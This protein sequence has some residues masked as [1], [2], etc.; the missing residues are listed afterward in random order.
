MCECVCVCI[1]VCMYI[2][3]KRSSTFTIAHRPMQV[4]IYTFTR[5]CTHA[6]THIRTRLVAHTHKHTHTHAR[7]NTNT[8]KI[9]K[10]SIYIFADQLYMHHKLL[11]LGDLILLSVYIIS[12]LVD[13]A[14]FVLIIND[15]KLDNI[16]GSS[17]L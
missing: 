14:L 5:S 6:L 2:Y 7:T 10:V 16:A 8:F 15:I 9:S 17:Q 12:Y 13:S 4:C 3:R 11:R 1:C